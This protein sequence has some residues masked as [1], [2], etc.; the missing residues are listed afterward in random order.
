MDALDAGKDVLFDIDWQGAEQVA[1]KL[2][3]DSVRVFILP[4]SMHELS[5]RLHARAQDSQKVI[6]GRLERAYGEIAQW[7][8]YDYVIVNLDYDH[9]YADLAHIYHA[10][11][12]KKDRQTWAEPFVEGLLAEKV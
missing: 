11:R 3:E 9:A 8:A 1:D 6:E 4:P 7:R 2:P 5:R 10:E 12:L